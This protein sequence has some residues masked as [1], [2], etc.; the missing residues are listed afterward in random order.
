MLTLG[1]ISDTHVPD[2]TA[3]LN[4][5][6][7]E[8]FRAARAA[9]ILH[10]GDISTPGVL[11]QL[12]EVAPVYAVKGNRD[13]VALNHLPRTRLLPFEGLHVGLAH[14]HGGVWRYFI[15]KLDYIREGYRFERMQQI[16]GPAFPGA[17]VIVFGHSHRPVNERVNGILWFNPGS[18][19]CTDFRDM[20]PSVGLLHIRENSAQGEIIPLG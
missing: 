4:P 2:K 14:G 17:Q 15:G 1:I 9:A 5:Q 18:A 20:P 11:R 8:I 6:A 3:R 16:L 13:W 19:C 10:A 12:G 7:L